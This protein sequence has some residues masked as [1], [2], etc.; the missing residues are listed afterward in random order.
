MQKASFDGWN[1]TRLLLPSCTIHLMGD[2]HL[3]RKFV[4]DVPIHDDSR[5]EMIMMCGLP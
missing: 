2:P 1:G 5:G 4:N 3:G